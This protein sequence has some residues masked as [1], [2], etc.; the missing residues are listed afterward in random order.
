MVALSVGNEGAGSKGRPDGCQMDVK[1]EEEAVISLA[2]P[3]AYTRACL[4]D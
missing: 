2:I 1:L 3:F 4:M